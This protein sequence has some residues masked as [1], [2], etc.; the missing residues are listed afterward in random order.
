MSTDSSISIYNPAMPDELKEE[1]LRKNS[2]AL[3]KQANGQ[4]AQIVLN[5]STT[6]VVTYSTT[7]NFIEIKEFTKSFTTSGGLIVFSVSV[8]IRSIVNSYSSSLAL[9]VDD[10][11]LAGGDSFTNGCPFTAAKNMSAGSHTVKLYIRTNQ[12]SDTWQLNNAGTVGTSVLQ[13]IEYLI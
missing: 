1:A 3:Y 7:A 11:L 13:A 8:S 4:A 12:G 5:V 9:I 2:E 6:D 10:V